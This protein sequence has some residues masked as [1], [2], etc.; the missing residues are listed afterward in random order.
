[1]AWIRWQVRHLR[2]DYGITPGRVLVLVACMVITWFALVGA[3]CIGG[4]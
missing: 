2:E 1:M 3:C 4:M